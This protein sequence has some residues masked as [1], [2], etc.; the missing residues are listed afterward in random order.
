[1][2]IK[3][4]QIVHN[5]Q[6]FEN[7]FDKADSKA[8]HNHSQSSQA[9]MDY[10]DSQYQQNTSTSSRKFIKT[11][12]QKLKSKR[13]YVTLDKQN[14]SIHKIDKKLII[15]IRNNSK[16]SAHNFVCKECRL[17]QSRSK[18]NSPRG[19]PQ[20]VQQ[21]KVDIQ[22]VKDIF[23]DT[24]DES[25]DSFDMNQVVSFNMERRYAAT[26]KSCSDLNKVKVRMLQLQEKLSQRTSDMLNSPEVQEL[27]GM[28]KSHQLGLKSEF[29]QKIKDLNQDQ[30]IKDIGRLHFKLFYL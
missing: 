4:P 12:S 26:L 6:K 13:L 25:R 29:E 20:K 15:P 14:N 16:E 11:S 22:N 5:N 9:G 1:M 8:Q 27:I 3:I 10:S 28:Y 23:L 21:P 2:R 19:S 24:D 30:G 18:F 17:E 7:S